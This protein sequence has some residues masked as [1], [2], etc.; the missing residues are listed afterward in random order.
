VA[1]FFDAASE[2][3]PTCGGTIASIGAYESWRSDSLSISLGVD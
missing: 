3:L 2:E 1:E